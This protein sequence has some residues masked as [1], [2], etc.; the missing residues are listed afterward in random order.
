MISIKELE[1][2]YYRGIYRPTKKG[3]GDQAMPQQYIVFMIPLDKW[4]EL[5]ESEKVPNG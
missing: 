5:K 4:I 2:K 1:Q 3:T